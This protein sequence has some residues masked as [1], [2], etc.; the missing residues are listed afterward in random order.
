MTNR[1]TIIAVILA[2]IAVF[3]TA[4]V[5]KH[6]GYEEGY[7]TCMDDYELHEH[8]GVGIQFLT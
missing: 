6:V 2:V 5:A 3:A 1:G 4:I 7:N 8:Y